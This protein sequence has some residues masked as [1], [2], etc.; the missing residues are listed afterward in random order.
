MKEL[1]ENQYNYKSFPLLLN[2]FRRAGTNNDIYA[3][4]FNKYDSPANLYFRIF[5]DFN[6][7]LLDASG[8][9]GEP[10]TQ[11]NEELY[12]GK[13]S[14]AGNIT[15]LIYNNSALNYLVLNNEWERADMLRQFIDLLSNI[16]T[17]SPWYFQEI[18][19]V[20]QSLKR[21]EVTGESFTIPT[22]E[23]LVI[24][25]L[26]D[27]YDN[28]IGTLLDLY[29]SICYSYQLH[30]EILPD[31]L[32]TFTMYLYIF[33]TAIRGVHTRTTLTQNAVEGTPYASDA[34]INQKLIKKNVVNGSVTTTSSNQQL[35]ITSSKLIQFNYCQ[36]VLDSNGTGYSELKNDEGF[37]QKYQIGIKYANAYEQRYNEILMKTIGDWILGDQDLQE[38]QSP[39]QIRN[40]DEADAATK[41][42]SQKQ[43]LKN[44]DENQ[45]N[46]PPSFISSIAGIDIPIPRSSSY[47]SYVNRNAASKVGT[48]MNVD[49]N[50][51]SLLDP[52][53]NMLK[54]KMN[55]V[56]QSAKNIVNAGKSAIESWVDINKLNKNLASSIQALSFGNLFTTNLTGNMV[57]EANKVASK[58]NNQNSKQVLGKTTNGWRHNKK[59]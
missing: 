20:D 16:S 14:E 24:T 8:D 5:F 51:T 2:A 6:H 30:K 40:R 22:R 56:S 53:T 50:R 41:L 57:N 3:K 27:A 12:T 15:P 13:P 23:P 36:F 10:G 18:A 29:K 52:W 28:R 47:D 4:D 19:G 42:V 59:Q 25:C 11:I 35:Y 44:F 38:G 39:I 46:N 21:E 34:T 9:L 32:R 1:V 26:P 33:N 7:G 37:Q 17:Y 43:N 31:N 58:I 55:D 48:N 45:H 54:N 49:Q